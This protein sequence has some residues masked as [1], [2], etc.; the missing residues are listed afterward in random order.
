V[1]Y[2]AP[3]VFLHGVAGSCRT[4]DW[5]PATVAGH[6]IV[7]PDFRGHGE[8]PRTPG[9]YLI[10]DYAADAIEVLRSTGPAFVVGHSLGAVSAW[11]AAQ[12]VPELVRGAV[13][14]DPPLFLG[15][16][17]GHASNG[18]V[19]HFEHLRAIVPAWRSEGV[20]EAEAAARLAA[21]P[22]GPDPSRRAGEVAMRDA[23]AARAYSLLHLD[24]TVLDP[25]IDGSLLAAT[26]VEAPITVPMTILAAGLAPA[27]RPE[28][29]ARL[30]V[31]HPAIEVVTVAGA[32]HSIH[33][34]RASRATYLA[35]V[36]RF[37][38]AQAATA[39]S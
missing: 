27:F 4:Y 31:T 39:R 15:S 8:A 13:L 37:L 3:V 11:C 7:R 9:S 23:I 16:P 26:D 21:E 6:E 30:A 19:P 14:E 24:E 12:Q 28:H 20:L 36:E 33:D 18:A 17:R 34:E 35:Q 25:V 10:S 32:G 38:T 1:N 22:Y 2:L 29:A 5:L